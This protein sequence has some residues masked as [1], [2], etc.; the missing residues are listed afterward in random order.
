M[1]EKFKKIAGV[2]FIIVIVI[3]VL[4]VSLQPKSNMSTNTPSPLPS[5]TK[6]G[7]VELPKDKEFAQTIENVVQQYPWYPKLP[8]ETKDYRIIYDFDN[9]MFRIR[10][11]STTAP[12]EI[13]TLTQSALNDLKNIGVKDPI[14]YYLLDSNGNQL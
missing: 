9:N 11:L 3:I 12:I 4:I 14:K 1:K 8:I 6:P 7:A 5:P 10:F 2:V 13:K